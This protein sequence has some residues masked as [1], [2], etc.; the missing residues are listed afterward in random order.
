[1]KASFFTALMNIDLSPISA[2]GDQ[3]ATG[4]YITTDKSVLPELIPREVERHIGRLEAEFLQ[5]AP[6]IVYSREDVGSD[7]DWK[8]YLGERLARVKMFFHTMWLFKDNAA[9]CE[10]GF[11][12]Y[13]V[14]ISY[15]THSNALS[16]AYGMADGSKTVVEFSRNDLREI[17]SF[18]RAWIGEIVFQT[19]HGVLSSEGL[20][21]V[22][23][24]FYWIQAGRGAD[25][26]GQ[27]I[28]SFCTAMESLFATSTSELAHQLS[29]RMAVFLSDM[30]DERAKIYREV[31]LAY[32]Y[33]SKV[34]HGD[35]LKHSRRTKLIE[36]A[37]SC[38][39]LL[40]QAIRKAVSD[41]A[42]RTA[43]E[44]S[45]EALD[46]YFLELLFAS[47]SPGHDANERQ[48]CWRKDEV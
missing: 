3:I 26:I 14:G 32:G 15:Q 29:E 47:N 17:R 33:R 24:A 21:R 1:M 27:R 45:N 37:R 9:D 43:L 31:K 41:D 28:A 8:N 20:E 10:L 38:D 11:L 42:S 34:V 6:A 13:P 25:G 46:R 4:L 44:S 18:Y 19:P 40:R 36:V 35:V 23:R 22:A 7:F 2:P 16:A 12:M 39:E 30:P 5:N 48:H